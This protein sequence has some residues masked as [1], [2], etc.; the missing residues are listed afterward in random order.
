MKCGSCNAWKQQSN[1]GMT[2]LAAYALQL[3]LV[4]ERMLEKP[5]DFTHN[6]SA[7]MQ[8]GFLTYSLMDNH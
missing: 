3:V 7:N 4:K 5:L 1:Y 6:I 8:N 2:S